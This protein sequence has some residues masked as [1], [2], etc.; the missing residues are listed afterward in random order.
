MFAFA[1]SS[2]ETVAIFLL[3]LVLRNAP[4]HVALDVLIASGSCNGFFIVFISL[5]GCTARQQLQAA[6]MFAT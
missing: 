4:Q 3:P 5:E 6:D 2:L 1:D